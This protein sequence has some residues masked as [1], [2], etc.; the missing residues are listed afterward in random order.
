M[1]NFIKKVDELDSLAQWFIAEFPDISTYLFV[2]DLGA[3]KTTFIKT[4]AKRLG[5]SVD[6]NSPTFSIINEYPI[7]NADRKVFHIDLYRLKSEK[8]AIDLGI[9]EYLYS[10]HYCIIEW[11]QVIE[12]LLPMPLVVTKIEIEDDFSRRFEVERVD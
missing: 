4:F 10:D 11:P 12:G 7:D 8:E 2:G 3:G 6:V 9:E 5:V 1:P